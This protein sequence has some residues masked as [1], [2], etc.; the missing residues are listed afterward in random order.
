MPAVV[1]TNIFNPEDMEQSHNDPS[2]ITTED[3][4]KGIFRDLGIDKSTYGDIKHRNLHYM[5]SGMS[6]ESMMKMANDGM[7]DHLAKKAAEKKEDVNKK[8]QVATEL[9]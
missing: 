2:A 8:N 1:K 5:M 9:A 4:V 7:R 3:A 6:R